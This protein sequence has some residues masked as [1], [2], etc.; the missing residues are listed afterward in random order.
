MTLALDAPEAEREGLGDF[1]EYPE[2][3]SSHLH[4][5]AKLKCGTSFKKGKGEV[6]EVSTLRHTSTEYI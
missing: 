2:F 5:Q 4:C 3:T 6:S 1:L